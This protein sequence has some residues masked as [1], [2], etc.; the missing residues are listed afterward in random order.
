MK[1]KIFSS[2]YDKA[3][4]QCEWGPPTVF[5]WF[6]RYSLFDATLTLHQHCF[7]LSLASLDACFG[8]SFYLALHLASQSVVHSLL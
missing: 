5:V 2:M 4:L 8:I 1:L 6:A 7:T 3:I